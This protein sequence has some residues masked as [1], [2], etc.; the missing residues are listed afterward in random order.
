MSHAEALQAVA[1]LGPNITAEV[2]AAFALGFVQGAVS[3]A[4]AAK[5]PSPSSKS[6]TPS[7]EDSTVCVS[8][9]FKV[10]DVEKFKAIWKAPYVTYQLY[11]RLQF[12]WLEQFI[13]IDINIPP[14]PLLYINR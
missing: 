1:A 11:V 4:P 7:L 12:S 2:A 3:N 5:E 10:L 8:P 6:P 14:P 9:Y 13:R